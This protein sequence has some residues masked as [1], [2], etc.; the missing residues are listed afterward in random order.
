[1]DGSDDDAQGWIFF[2][3]YYGTKKNS[4]GNLKY[5]KTLFVSE[6]VFVANL[7]EICIFYI[8]FARMLF[9]TFN[10]IFLPK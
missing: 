2:M 9:P 5:I 1:M 4:K 8:T 3:L 6:T 10:K 7:F